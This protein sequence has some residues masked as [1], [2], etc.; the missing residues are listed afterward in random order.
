MHSKHDCCFVVAAE[1]RYSLD[2][3][4]QLADLRC[5]AAAAEKEGF[6]DAR[7][8]FKSPGKDVVPPSAACVYLQPMMTFGSGNY[9]D[10]VFFF[11]CCVYSARSNRLAQSQQVP[12]NAHEAKTRLTR[13]TVGTVN[14]NPVRFSGVPR[15]LHFNP[16]LNNK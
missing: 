10:F 16:Y 3:D 8:V 9:V 11:L 6:V 2:R 13:S 1:E 14:F 4:L 5:D 15:E 12:T 7:S